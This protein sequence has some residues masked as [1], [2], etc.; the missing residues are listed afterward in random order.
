MGSLQKGGAFQ[1]TMHQ[2]FSQTPNSNLGQ[3]VLVSP[4]KFSSFN[5]SQS[6]PI[7]Q[8]G[9]GTVVEGENEIIQQQSRSHKGRNFHITMFAHYGDLI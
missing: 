4:F 8:D 3:E 5:S 1:P 7:E 6:F 2:T 9:D